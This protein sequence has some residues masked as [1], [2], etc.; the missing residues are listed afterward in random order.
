MRYINRRFTYLLT[1]KTKLEIFLLFLRVL[2]FTVIHPHHAVSVLFIP[3]MTI[4]AAERRPASV[5]SRLFTVP[6]IQEV[7]SRCGV[8]AQW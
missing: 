7:W 2:S 6:Q 8:L 5:S 3:K 4:L 1:D